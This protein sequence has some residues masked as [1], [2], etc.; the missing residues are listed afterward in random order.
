MTVMTV[1]AVTAVA[2]I[3][4]NTVSEGA[5]LTTRSACESGR[6]SQKGQRKEWPIAAK[7]S[8]AFG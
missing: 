5:F 3:E 7:R 1:M 8:A 4:T 2:T 6:T